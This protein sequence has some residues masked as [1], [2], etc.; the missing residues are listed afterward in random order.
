MHWK[1]ASRI[2]FALTIIAIGIMGLVSG[3]FAPIW[4]G[5]PKSLPD[6]QL[7]AYSCTVISLACGAGLL[8]K[9]TARLAALALLAYLVIWTAL[10]KVPFIVR[11]PLVE[12]SYQSCGENLVLIAAAWVLYVWSA[13]GRAFPAGDIGI[14]GGHLLYGVALIAFGFSHFAYLNLTAPLIPEWLRDPI[15]WAYFT[16]AAYVAAGAAI[17]TGIAGRLGAVGSALQIS[18]ITLLVWGPPVIAGEFDPSN[19]QE[20]VVSWAL[21]ASACVI[22]ASF[23][24]Y[25]WLKPLGFGRSTARRLA[26]S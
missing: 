3:S 1:A 5:V 16:G 13:N 22:A 24:D 14:R 4:A 23:G 20:P 15:F 10:F 6:R 12:V 19:W 17:I 2:V 8:M 26:R 9:R 25:P 18:L 11:Q 21:T 7:L